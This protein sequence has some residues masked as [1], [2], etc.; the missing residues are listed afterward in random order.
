[1]LLETAIAVTAGW[2]LGKLGDFAASKDKKIAVKKA[3]ESSLEHAY[4]YFQKKNGKKADLFFNKEFLENHICPELQK[5]LTRNL[6][7]DIESVSNALPVNALFVSGNGFRDEIKEFFDMVLSSMK[8]YAA[9]QDIINNRQIDETNQVVKEAYENQK[10][11]NK[12][13]EDNLNNITFQQDISDK[14]TDQLFSQNA[15]NERKADQIISLLNDKLPDSKGN[16]LNEFLTKQLDR[17]RDLINF[18][19]VDSAQELLL[20]MEDEVSATDDYTRFRWHTNVG[21]CLLS[22]DD[23]QEAAAQ[24]LTA[25][26]FA[27]GEEKAVAN[28]I[29]A[30]LLMNQFE[31][32]LKQSI[33]ALEDYPESGMIWALHIN[34]KSFLNID[35]DDSSLPDGLKNDGVILLMLSDLKLREKA[36]KESFNLAKDAYE[37]DKASNGTK[38]AM[39]A[40]A[41]SWATVDAVKSHYGQFSTEQYDALKIAVDSFEDIIGFLKNIQS[42][43]VFTEVA[44]NLAIATDLLGQNMLKDDITAYAFASYPDENVFIWYKVKQ[45]KES[46]DIQAIHNLTDH[47]Y[48]DF[49]KYFLFTLAEISAN[50][51]DVEWNN[52]VL[53]SLAKKGLEDKESDELFGMKLCAIWKSGN[54]IKTI[55]L[56][57]DNL[58]KITSYPSLLSFYIRIL[59]EYGE[60]EEHSKL[61]QSCSNLPI[62]ASSVE[63]IQIADLLYDYDRYFEASKLYCRI[64]DHPSDD[65][66]TKRYL[67]SLIKS[68]QRAQA[69]STL[70]NLPEE[71]RN[72]SSFKRMEANLARASGDLDKLEYIFTGELKLYPCDSGVAAGYVATLYRKNKIEELNDYLNTN[73][74]YDPIIEQNEIEI[75]KY[76]MEQGLEHYA[77]LRMYSLFRSHPNSSQIAGHFL[78]LPLLAKQFDKLTALKV[79]TPGV[80]IYLESEG[81]RKTIV[82]EPISLSNEGGWPECIKEDNELAEKLIGLNIGDSIAIYSGIG[83]KKFSII[84][85]DSMFIFASNIAHKVIADSASSVGPVWCVNVRKPD[86]EYDFSPILESVKSRSQHVEHVFSVYEEKKFPLQML[87]DALETDVVTLLLEWPYKQYDLFVCAGI[88]E[89]REGIKELISDDN[90]PYII[91]LSC[92]VELLRLRLL[93]ESLNILGRPLVAASLKEQ[94]LGQLQIHNKLNPSGV[95]SEI[96][97]RLTYRDI[98]KEELEGRK[99][100]LKALLEFVDNHCEVVPVIGPKV[101]TEQQAAI[102]EHIGFSSHDAIYLT[103]ERDG[104]LVSEDGGFRSLAM[105]MGV[106]SS[107]WL[108]PLLMTLRD[109]NLINEEQYSKSILNKL[110]RRHSFTSVTANDLLWSA[111]TYTNSISPDV[112][113][114]FLTFKNPTLDLPSGVVVGSQFLRD[115][116]KHISPNVLFQ[117]YK[118]ILESL[119]HGREKYTDNIQESLRVHIVSALPS[120]ERKKAKVI[121]RKFGYLID[122]PQERRVQIRLQPLTQAIKLALSK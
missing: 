53:E 120:I 45:L 80:V 34:A 37:L 33:K 87:S 78:L 98:S 7:P 107:T 76:Q 77:L 14:K 39:L 2:L 42:K 32:G 55:E 20:N 44:H 118:L 67:D 112:K 101:V 82:I 25:Y 91:D 69:S 56:A 40:S 113:S 64:I 96:D 13:L 50:T 57:K 93:D 52:S 90:K 49:E 70:E 85:I 19:L 29:R 119:S 23:R 111:K 84:G 100:F 30:F 109:T 5:Y 11:T 3:L 66:L 62:E 41:L 72:Q 103:L 1:M 68:D 4:K 117:Y 6:D 115:A 27:K 114:A 43:H 65:Y 63:V 106:N 31:K 92:L 86:G 105:N 36:Y 51:G 16:E 21:A 47:K 89:E 10:G 88:H 81:E 24:Y 121:N 79:V 35:F 75:A 116:A 97:G 58:S 122:T 108:Q 46:G 71:I 54:K 22:K 28:R 59:D 110:N 48:E 94:L 83:L 74:I 9:L 104:I 99:E 73:P 17:A 60:L 15:V 38:R 8:E 102:G 18:G 95:A 26:N 12:R 61:L